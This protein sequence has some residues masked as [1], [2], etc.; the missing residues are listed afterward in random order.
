ME[1]IYAFILGILSV[2][3]MSGMVLGV[4]AFFK[5][6]RLK[7]LF[8]E[9]EE[10]SMECLDEQSNQINKRVDSVEKEIYEL[11]DSSRR[12]SDSRFDKFENR[13]E[14]KIQQELNLNKIKN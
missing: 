2:F 11:I 8:E 9:F 12:E 1:T 3:L 4:L 5:V 10:H 7:K 6:I 13:I 14:N